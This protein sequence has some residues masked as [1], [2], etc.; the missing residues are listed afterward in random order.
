MFIDET[1]EPMVK[2]NFSTNEA[3]AFFMCVAGVLS[4]GF[5]KGVFEFIFGLSSVL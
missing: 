1:D 2:L 3:V 4:I 5:L